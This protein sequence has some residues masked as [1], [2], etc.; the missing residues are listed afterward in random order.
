MLIEDARYEVTEA[1]MIPVGQV[2]NRFPRMIRDISKKEG[3]DVE[4]VVT[5]SE[6]KL[7]RT[8]LDQLGEPLIHL[9]RNSVDHGIECPADRE[10]AG[11]SK[12]GRIELIAKR[13]KNSVLIDIVDDGAGFDLDKIKEIAIKREIFTSA[14]VDIMS[15]KEVMQLPFR[16]GFTTS[17]KVTDVSGRGVGLDVVKTK[18]EG[19]NGAV[20]MDTLPGKG[21]T[22]GLKLPLTM[23]IV[24]CLLVTVTGMTYA[25]PISNI[26]RIVKVTSANI[27]HISDREVFI[28]GDEDIAMIRLC[29]TFHMPPDD[30]ENLTVLIVEHNGE[31]VGLVIDDIIGEQE[32]MIKSL[33][34]ELKTAKGFAGATILGEG[35]PALVLDVASII[36]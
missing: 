14:E 10:K 15:D 25:M 13:E 8:V 7:D 5:G 19:L 29:D 30:K 6:I 9:L 4:F 31:K 22:F 28:L 1:R 3:K 20:L 27:K 11:K 34:N 17:D 18:I 21:T 33:T 32:I 26:L 12:K 2:F 16:P 23:A 36:Q 35:H 24:K